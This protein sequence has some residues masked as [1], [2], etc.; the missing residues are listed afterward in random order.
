[1]KKLIYGVVL[2]SFFLS[3]C[4]SVP[5]I[6]QQDVKGLDRTLDL[7][8]ALDQFVKDFDQYEIVLVSLDKG[9]EHLKI[10]DAYRGETD[11]VIKFK[12]KGE[13]RLTLT[14]FDKTNAKV[15]GT[16]PIILPFPIS[17]STVKVKLIFNS[18][19]NAYG[20]WQNLGFENQFDIIRL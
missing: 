7:K 15:Y 11:I 20:K 12:Y 13:T 4:S 14:K 1:M 18:D 17:T 19:G 5:P 10:L 8:T 6:N 16:Y 3:G 9:K 2:L